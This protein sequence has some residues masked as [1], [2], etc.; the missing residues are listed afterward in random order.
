MTFT[1]ARKNRAVVPQWRPLVAAI[2][3]GAL[4]VPKPFDSASKT[5]SSELRDR[6]QAWRATP[7][8]V[9]ASE[10]IETAIVDGVEAE[11]IRPARTVTADDSNA[12]PLVKK[13]AMVVLGRTKQDTKTGSIS[14][15]YRESFNLRNA[16][17]RT[18][19]FPHDPYAWVDLALAEVIKAKNEAAKRSMRI[20]LQL[21]P[22]DRHVL[23]SAARF[24]L[25]LGDGELAH[26]IIKQNDATQT[27]PWLMAAE[28]AL[29]GLA[30]K[31]PTMFKRGS[32]L[33]DDGGIQPRHTSEL[34]SAIGTIYLADGHRKARKLFNAS[35]LDPTGNSLAQAEWATPQ[36]EGLV[37]PNVLARTADS[38]EARAF[39]AHWA[40]NFPAVITECKN[41]MAEELFSSRPHQFGSSAAI[42]IEKFD[43]ALN[44]ADR[45]LRLNTESEVLHNN[46]AYALVALERYDEAFSE[47]TECLTKYAEHLLGPITATAGMLSFRVGEIEEGVKRYN[48]AITIFRRIGNQVGEALAWAYFAQ[49]AARSN[50]PEADNIIRRAKNVCKIIR[51]LPEASI[52]IGRAEAW[53][54]AIKQR[55][56]VPID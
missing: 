30:E 33:I 37:K 52:V 14:S 21:A 27:D 28:I 19:L 31:K 56:G 47:L 44:F 51:H 48:D 7:N 4:A 9:T 29:S 34:A 55:A 2:S 18:R 35:L 43:V 16:R 8:L 22:H 10:V 25:H 3:N 5:I 6:L 11:A 53:M 38:A 13:Q 50:L 45:G 54:G 41:W 36:I 46:R 20:A 23:R 42:T 12:T 17:L 1:P 24:Y 49:E 32:A 26:H 39:Q 15:E 40:G